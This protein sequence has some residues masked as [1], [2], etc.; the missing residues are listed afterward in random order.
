MATTNRD[1]LEQSLSDTYDAIVDFAGDLV[2]TITNAKAAE[3]EK[4]EKEKVSKPQHI[5][6]FPADPSTF[7]PVGLRKVVHHGSKNG[8]LISWMDPVT[9]KEIFRWD[10][11]ISRNNGPHYHIRGNQG[12]HYYVGDEIPE[13]YASLYFPY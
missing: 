9:N 8:K 5:V 1:A 2:D 3:K 13:P 12:V 6:R 11:N 4:E 7:N 10:E